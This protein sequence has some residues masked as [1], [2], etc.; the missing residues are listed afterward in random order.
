MTRCILFTFLTA[1]A[2]A[3]LRADEPS[4]PRSE[5]RSTITIGRETTFVDGPL[6]S[7]GYIDYAA[8]LDRRNKLPAGEN[9]IAAL[10][11]IIGPMFDGRPVRAEYF[12]ALG[13][14]APP[15]GGEYFISQREFPYRSAVKI[16]LDAFD[17]Q[18]LAAW[19]PW[20]PKEL[21]LMAAWVGAN[22]RVADRIVAAAARPGLF[23]PVAVR[24][25]P[26]RQELMS[27][28]S[29]EVGRTVYYLSHL[30][31]RRATLR[32]GQGNF[33]AAWRDLLALHRIARLYACSPNSGQHDFGTIPD[34]YALLADEVFLAHA[35]GKQN[36]FA[37]CLA[38]LERLPAELPA[39]DAID[40]YRR[41]V[42]LQH[43]QTTVRVGHPLF[44]TLDKR[45]VSSN[46]AGLEAQAQYDLNGALCEA[47]R[48]CDR[49]VAANRIADRTKR[50]A[51]LK[52]IANEVKRNYADLNKRERVFDGARS[53]PA[54]EPETL[55]RFAFASSFSELTWGDSD[56]GESEY[57]QRFDNIRV[58]F[59]LA[60]FRTDHARY[61]DKLN[62]LF[63][64]YLA[65]IPKDRFSGGPLRY[66]RRGEGYLLYSIGKNEIDDQGRD[67]ADDP[68]SKLPD[69]NMRVPIQKFDDLRVRMPQ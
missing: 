57:D 27:R 43:L 58:A 15:V 46:P 19:Q 33:D 8:A 10:W 45:W 30:L 9:F 1:L 49:Y 51:E 42:M 65:A 13:I 60:A 37:R 3:P 41:F 50:R 53:G 61:P 24:P 16:D 64:R 21:P 67:W 25:Q 54:I 69:R 17:E 14:E 5:R 34:H 11:E 26:W 2:A 55:G 38:D 59:A 62:E 68:Q 7:A 29:D 22:E 66:E 31:V 56:A 18:G 23:V 32:I 40:G 44:E 28:T 12:A 39:A 4:P 63:P 36:R 6:D 20:L 52:R 47:N 35:D 48:L